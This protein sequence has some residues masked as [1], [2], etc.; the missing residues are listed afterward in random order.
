MPQ[1]LVCTSDSPTSFASAGG[2]PTFSRQAT[3]HAV[4][5]AFETRIIDALFS[6]VR[7]DLLALVAEALDAAGD[8]VADVQVLR[9]LHSE[10]HAGRRAGGDDVARE[11]CHEL[12][13][14]GD[15]VRAAED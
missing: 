5:R 2:T 12:A 14:V 6:G 1:T 4:R 9:R 13:D 3:D 15:E 7:D 8:D 11:E 10:A